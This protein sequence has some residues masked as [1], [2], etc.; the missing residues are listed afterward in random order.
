MFRFIL[1]RIIIII[2]MLFV[3]VSLTWVLVRLAPGNFY[4]G[5]KKL[6]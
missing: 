2:P 1:R 3:V 4:T 6:E 5:E